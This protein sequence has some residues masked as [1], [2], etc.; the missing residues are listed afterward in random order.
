MKTLKNIILAISLLICIISF[1][2]MII[3]Y[4]IKPMVIG[5][6]AMYVFATTFSFTLTFGIPN[7][8]SENIIDYGRN[9]G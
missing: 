2:I 5:I 8:E 4:F 7:D 9:L 6:I 3:C 1:I